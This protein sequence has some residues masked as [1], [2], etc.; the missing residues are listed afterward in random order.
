MARS[1]FTQP[2]EEHKE[3]CP[4][5]QTQDIIAGKWKI[6]ILWHLST[7]TRRFNEL[8]R[9]LPNISKGILTRQLRELEEDQMV[10][11]EVYKEVPPKVEYS[12]TPLGKSS[13]PIL[14]SMGEWSKKYLK[15]K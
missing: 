15:S 11:R 8:Q 4:V 2:P 9:L 14:H 3:V 5:T 12:L 10:H 1:W 13:L 6:I 7:K